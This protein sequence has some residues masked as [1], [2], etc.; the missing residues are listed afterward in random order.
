MLNIEDFSL[1]Q[2]KATFSELLKKT[3]AKAITKEKI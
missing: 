1:T 3:Q 2:L